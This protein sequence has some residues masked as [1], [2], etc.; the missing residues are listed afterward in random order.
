MLGCD[1][2]VPGRTVASMA[3][4]MTP[5]QVPAEMIATGIQWDVKAEIRGHELCHIEAAGAPRCADLFRPYHA[6][7]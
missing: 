2:P 7:A 1:S 3:E 4:N 5:K 6:I